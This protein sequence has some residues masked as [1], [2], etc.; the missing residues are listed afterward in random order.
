MSQLPLGS[1]LQVDLP[2]IL[3]LNL[4]SQKRVR[5]LHSGRSS[6]E[7][8]ESVSG[9]AGVVLRSR[10]WRLSPKT[11]CRCQHSETSVGRPRGINRVLPYEWRASH[12]SRH[13]EEVRYTVIFHRRGDRL[14]VRFPGWNAL[15]VQRI[16]HNP[17]TCAVNGSGSQ[18]GLAYPPRPQPDHCHVR[19]HN[20]LCGRVHVCP[21]TAGPHASRMH[22]IRNEGSVP[23]STIAVQLVPHDP[24]KANRRIDAPA[25]ETCSNIQ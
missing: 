15:Q 14:A 4:S 11:S 25:P 9:P 10:P 12:H 3:V 8:R 22:I 24:T 6:A 2:K 1:P 13:T 19:K 23:A 5:V 21:G 7:L 18:H 20:G 17:R 16:G